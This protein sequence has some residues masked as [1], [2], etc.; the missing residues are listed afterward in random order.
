VTF[1]RGHHSPMDDDPKAFA[2]AIADFCAAGDD[3][4]GED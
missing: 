1:P 3:Q 4:K 2:Q